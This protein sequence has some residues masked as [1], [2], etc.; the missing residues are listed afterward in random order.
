MVGKD[1]DESTSRQ[2]SST[3]ALTS[4]QSATSRPIVSTVAKLQRLY[5][6]AQASDAASHSLVVVILSLDEVALLVQLHC[7]LRQGNGL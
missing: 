2:S 5:R 3:V 1:D 7:P 4:L 6:I